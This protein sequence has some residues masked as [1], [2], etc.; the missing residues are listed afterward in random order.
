MNTTTRTVYS[1]EVFTHRVLWKT[2]R[3]MKAH[4]VQHAEGRFYYSISAML[5]ARLTLEAYANF[6]LHVLYPRVYG[7]EKSRF[8]SS[9]DAKL[10]WIYK[11]LGIPLDRGRRPYQTLPLLDKFRDRVVHGKPDVYAGEEHHAPEEEP[12]PMQ[13]GELERAVTPS[14]ARAWYTHIMAGGLARQVRR[15]TG[16]VSSAAVSDPSAVLRLEHYARIQTTLTALVSR[17][18]AQKRGRPSEF[19]N[20]VIRTECVHIVTFQENYAAMRHGG[21]YRRAGIKLVSWNRIPRAKRVR[22]WRRMLKGRV[23]NAEDYA[24]SL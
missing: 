9:T 20:T 8:G 11:E 5:M 1:G 4:A 15:F 24:A 17:H 6:L 21:N 2:A 12:S 3:V 19:V 16:K 23:A 18:L 22:L 7:E 10:G 13:M 14:A